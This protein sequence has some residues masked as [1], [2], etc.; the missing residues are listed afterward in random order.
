[1][2]SQAKLMQCFVTVWIAA[3]KQYLRNFQMQSHKMVGSIFGGTHRLISEAVSHGVLI[4]LSSALTFVHL[5]RGR[6]QNLVIVAA[7]AG[8]RTHNG[9]LMCQRSIES[10]DISK[11]MVRGWPKAQRIRLGYRIVVYEPIE[12]SSIL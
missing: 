9:L 8:N 4:R 6:L 10:H 7:K 12:I 5:D 1:M 11:E 2:E 3:A